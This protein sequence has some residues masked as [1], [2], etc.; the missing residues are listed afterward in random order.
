MAEKLLSRFPV[1]KLEEMPKDIRDQLVAVQARTGFIPNVFVVLAHR[2]AEL[3]A[4]MAYYQALMEKDEGLTKAEREMIVVATSAANSCPYCVIAHG[5]ILRIRSR[6]PLL[7][8]QLTVNYR[9]ADIS[10]RQRLMLDFA[11]QVSQAA[12]ALEEAD[13]ARLREAGFGEDEIWDIGAIAALFALSNRMAA[14]TA[15]WPNEEFYTLGRV[16]PE[17]KEE[18]AKP[19]GGRA[20][21]KG[22]KDTK[23]KKKGKVERVSG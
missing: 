16:A 18:R 10:P 8:D 14:L 5:A 9:L 21:A 17:G 4:F 20:S 2:P 1:P 22:T 12:E 6:Q 13:F 11:L 15:M 19:K 23:G 3:R 7:A